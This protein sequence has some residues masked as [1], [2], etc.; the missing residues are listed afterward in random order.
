MRNIHINKLLIF[1]IC[2]FLCSATIVFFAFRNRQPAEIIETEEIIEEEEERD[3]FSRPSGR[4]IENIIFFINTGILL[5]IW[6]NSKNNKNQPKYKECCRYDKDNAFSCF[7]RWYDNYRESFAR[8]YCSKE[9]DGSGLCEIQNWL[10]LATFVSFFV[11]TL[12]VE[13]VNLFL[14][15][16]LAY[17]HSKD[18]N[19]RYFHTL[20]IHILR[21]INL[22]WEKK[23][24]PEFILSYIGF[25]LSVILIAKLTPK[26]CVIIE[27]H[28]AH[29][30]CCFWN[31][32]KNKEKEQ[33]NQKKII[34][35]ESDNS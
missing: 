25:G 35:D 21:K 3:F 5:F 12:F 1:V 9:S 26:Y 10:G 16:S 22:F 7:D 29:C 31:I 17:L 15:G 14:L 20:K 6:E 23:I 4:A 33:K 34:T 32:S 28:N 27:E 13:F 11:I 18:K 24:N 8:I 2:S 30:C 19:K